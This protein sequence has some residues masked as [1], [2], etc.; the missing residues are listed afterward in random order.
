MQ[1]NRLLE[2]ANYDDLIESSKLDMADKASLCEKDEYTEDESDSDSDSDI[3]GQSSSV[4]SVER[5]I[6]ALL[7]VHAAWLQ[8]AADRGPPYKRLRELVETADAANETEKRGDDALYSAKRKLESAS[9]F[10]IVKQQD[11]V[12]RQRKTVQV[13]RSE[14]VR[15]GK[16]IDLCLRDIRERERIVADW[17]KDVF[18]EWQNCVPELRGRKVCAV[19]P[20]TIQH[21]VLGQ[22]LPFTQLVSENRAAA[23]VGTCI[24]E[25]NRVVLAAARRLLPGPVQAAVLK[26]KLG[27]CVLGLSQFAVLCFAWLLGHFWARVA[28][29]LVAM[30]WV[31][32]YHISRHEGVFVGHLLFMFWILSEL[33]V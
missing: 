4:G 18:D 29:K 21:D 27:T 9:P 26:H 12:D 25:T 13:A 28:G 2:Y 15:L 3:E 1:C 10:D 22:T 7:H 6:K 5:S 30:S 20:G 23:W 32:G 19:L 14:R 17:K 11:V 31:L 8:A 16:N 33:G 24:I